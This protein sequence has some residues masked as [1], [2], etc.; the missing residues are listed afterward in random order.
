MHSNDTGS[1]SITVPLMGGTTKSVSPGT[2]SPGGNTPRLN[3]LMSLPGFRLV[4]QL[5]GNIILCRLVF[6]ETKL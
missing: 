4:K 5:K 3:N 2:F 1:P 6:K